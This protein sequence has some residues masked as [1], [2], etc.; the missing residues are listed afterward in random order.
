MQYATLPA[1]MAATQVSYASFNTGAETITQPFTVLQYPTLQVNRTPQRLLHVIALAL[2]MNPECYRTR[3]RVRSIVELR[4][5]ASLLLRRYFPA[6]T[7]QQIG[8]YFG[9]QDHTSV[10]N[11]ISRANELI[12]VRDA[13]FVKKYNTVINSVNSWLKRG[14]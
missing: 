3:S 1:A 10:I 8:A 4:F 6:L 2:D 13:S 14:V 5:L 12:Y 7:L 11:G 9:G